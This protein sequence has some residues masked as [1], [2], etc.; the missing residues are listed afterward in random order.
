MTAR[1][2]LSLLLLG[3]AAG[4]RANTLWTDHN[5]PPQVLTRLTEGQ[6]LA[7]GQRYDE[8]ESRI[9]EAQAL[10]PEHPLCGVFLVATLLSR[11]QEQFKEGRKEVPAD[12]FNE[13]DHLV[14]QAQAQDQDYPASP[15]P[16]LYLGAAYGVRGLAKLY[17]GSYIAS[18]FDGKKGAALLRE[19]VTIDPQLY[20]AYMGL[21]QFEYYCGTL[22]GV[23]QFVLAL[24]GNPDKGLAMLKECEE[25]ATYACWPCKV[26]RVGLLL[27]DRKDYKAA[28]PELAALLAR[29]PGNLQFCR[30][31]FDALE[32][33]G[34]TAALR[35]SAEEVL[36]RL[37]Q[38]WQPPQ[39]ARLDPEWCRLTLGRA[40]LQAGEPALAALQFK[41]LAE[42]GH[43]E[44]R[45]QARDLLKDLPAADAAGPMPQPLSPAARPADA[46]ARL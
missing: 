2:L 42:Q 36:R 16:K 30:A 35:R 39:Y 41:R 5:M 33:G 1:L 4:L 11:V 21:G 25:K 19:A 18:Y 28:E 40:Y 13:I 34:N 43:G 45:Q 27:S 23:L 24:P 3:P 15:Y 29:Y 37:D 31:A 6:D 46:A 38:G 32:A 26:Y 8:A 9:R 22:S 44:L 17:A 20:N 10:A 12:F 14:A 7:L